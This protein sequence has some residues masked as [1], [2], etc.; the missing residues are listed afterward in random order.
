MTQ[1]TTR[2]TYTLFL[3]LAFT[4]IILVYAAAR[5]VD[6]FNYLSNF[7]PLK[8]R[9]T[10]YLSGRIG[11]DVTVEKVHA[12]ILPRPGIAFTDVKI[13]RPEGFHASAE[14]ILLVFSPRQKLSGGDWLARISLRR[15]R[16]AVRI[17]DATGAAPLPRFSLPE[18]ELEDPSVTIQT[19]ENTIALEGPLTGHVRVVSGN[20]LSLVGSLDFN[21][22]GIRYN[23]TAVELDGP[24]MMNGNSLSSP[25][26]DIISG[27]LTVS[28]QGNY[29]WKEGRS[30]AGS[31]RIKG[32]TVETKSGGNP[33]LDA[34]LDKLNGSAD[35]TLAGM[36]LFGIPL[37]TVTARAIATN[38]TVVLNDLRADGGVLSGSGTVTLAPKRPAL[39]DVTFTLRNYD[40]MKLLGP[41]SSGSTLIRGT[42]D[43][44]G[45]VW[46]TGGSINGDVHFSSFNG[47]LM[48]FGPLFKIFTTVNF[49]RMIL[50]KHPDYRS[51]GFPYNSIISQFTI[52]DSTVSFDRFY[53]DSD[54]LQVSASGTYSMQ[55][56]A[57][58]ALLGVRPLDLID[59]TVGMIPVLGW[60]VEG[61]E[62]AAVIMYFR[63]SGDIKDPGVLPAP[64]QNI[65]RGIGGVILRTLML[66]YTIFTKPW[67][68]IPALQY[69][70]QTGAGTPEKKR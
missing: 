69:N 17:D 65:T 52:R 7:G 13:G 54:S 44:G 6:D 36:T 21:R 47:R 41:V 25:G 42:M 46:G 40:I 34:I 45:R 48:K 28:A 57:V 26:L 23:D 62:N 39:F 55:S 35:L 50:K 53:L 10:G 43:L 22:T 68:L 60:I 37:D 31:V 63:M 14:G 18:I 70:R 15:L 12:T 29:S 5:A 64:M 20:T 33:V 9:L 67:N 16:F 2:L 1:G 4:L 59:R 58:N 24:V 8:S 3:Y 27:G 56:H 19:R 66:P 51:R 49:H 38:G 30:F 32:L 61:K 11:T